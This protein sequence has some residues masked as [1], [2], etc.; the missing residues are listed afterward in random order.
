MMTT[1]DSLPAR[2]SAVARLD[3]PAAVRFGGAT[4][5]GQRRRLAPMQPRSR[6]S[7]TTSLRQSPDR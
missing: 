3:R 7:F 6:T 4:R 2:L 5:S 1:H